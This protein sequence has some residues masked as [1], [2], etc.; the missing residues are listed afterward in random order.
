MR[1]QSGPRGPCVLWYGMAVGCVARIL[2]YVWL[3]FGAKRI[4]EKGCGMR[5]SIGRS[6]TRDQR[7]DW[8]RVRGTTA[9]EEAG[10]ILQSSAA[11]KTQSLREKRRTTT[12]TSLRAMLSSL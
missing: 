6:E 8:S 2:W 9:R 10:R 12:S 3:G 4:K 7:P 5:V 11:E 1:G